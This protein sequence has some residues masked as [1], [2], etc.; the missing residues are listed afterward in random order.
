MSKRKNISVAPEIEITTSSYP[1]PSDRFMGTINIVT[2]TGACYLFIPPLLVFAVL[3]IQIIT[4]KS[5]NLRLVYIYIYII[6]LLSI[7]G[8]YG[9]GSL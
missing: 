9:Y 2:S 3:M 7:I 1:L 4:E 5:H 8:T 6:S